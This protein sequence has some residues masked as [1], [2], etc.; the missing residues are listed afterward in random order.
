MGDRRRNKQAINGLATLAARP[1]A[2]IPGACLSGG[3]GA[4]RF[5]D[6]EPRSWPPVWSPRKSTHRSVAT[7][8]SGACL[9]NRTA[10]MSK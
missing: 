9:T 4:Y 1:T 8:S 5:F 6:N 10:E 2:S 7:R 3:D